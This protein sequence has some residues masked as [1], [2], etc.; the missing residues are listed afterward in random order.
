MQAVLRKRLAMK[1]TALS[2]GR[3]RGVVCVGDIVSAG[4]E[5][6][7]ETGGLV[8]VRKGGVELSIN[9]TG[10]PKRTDSLG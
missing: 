4:E 9:W 1:P 3:G 10:I 8:S 7:F 5:A 2:V 6:A